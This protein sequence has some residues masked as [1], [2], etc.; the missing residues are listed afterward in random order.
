MDSRGAHYEDRIQELEERDDFKDQL[1]S[2]TIKIMR[3]YE[4]WI[5]E[6]LDDTKKTKSKWNN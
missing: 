5:Q 6:L 4:N 3:G 1:P 2:D